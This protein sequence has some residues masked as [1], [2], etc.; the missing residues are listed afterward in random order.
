[1]SKKPIKTQKKQPPKKAGFGIFLSRLILIILIMPVLIVIH[2]TII[3]LSFAML[4]TLIAFVLEKNKYQYKWLCIGGFNISGSFYYLLKMWFGS[5]TIT[6]ALN[7]LLDVT[8]L[9]VIYGSACFGL[10]VYTIF[11]IIVGTLSQLAAYRRANNLKIVQQKLI[12]NWGE[13]VKISE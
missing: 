7:I 8:S 5:H 12:E 6:E 1:M 11:P 4:P 9:I 2:P 13:E 3:F 10:L